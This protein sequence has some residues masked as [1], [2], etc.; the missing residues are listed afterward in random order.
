M[1]NQV[2]QLVSPRQIEVTYNNENIKSDKVIVRPLYLSICAADQRYYTGS[3]DRKVLEK[4]LPMSLI[5]EAVGEV[6]YDS[7]GIYDIGTKVIMV[8]NT[9]IEQ[10]KVISENYLPSSK[11][12]SSGYDGFMQD[13]VFMNHD[14][15][16]EI[17]VGFDLSVLAYSE[18]V[19]VSWHSIQRFKRKSIPKNESFGIWGDGNLGFITA[20]LLKNLYPNSKVYIFGKT[21]FK[22][23]HFS[24]VDDVF[25]INDI[26]DNLMIDHA[27]ECVGGKGSQSAINQIIDFISPEGS[28]ALLGVSEYPVEINTR[29]VLEKGL[30]MIGSSRSS[31]Q[32][33]KDIVSFYKQ[34]PDVLDKLSILKGEEFEVR[35][36]ND[37]I[38]AFEFDL[39]VSWGKTVIKW[40]M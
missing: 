29:L 23:S 11:F 13:Y 33:F 9:P 36:I 39:T 3:R 8:P 6:V 18:L 28:I 20:V 35:T 14:R 5:H 34:N 30:T 26:P 2:Y 40:I 27:F 16:A 24:F 21:E 1:I 19:S 7:K 37:I 10:D 15:L 17:P 12:R 4:K 25:N 38:Q 22:L 32:D 31:A